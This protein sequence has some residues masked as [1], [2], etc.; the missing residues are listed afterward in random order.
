MNGYRRCVQ[1]LD[2]RFEMK[3]RGRRK[4]RHRDGIGLEKAAGGS[5]FIAVRRARE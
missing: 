3:R 4:A 5:K 2:E 1:R